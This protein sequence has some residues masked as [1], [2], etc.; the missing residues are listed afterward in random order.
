[1]PLNLIRLPADYSDVT[2]ADVLVERE[3]TLNRFKRLW[4]EIMRGELVRNSFQPWEIDILLVLEACELEPR[5]R[6]EILRQYQR[7]V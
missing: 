2:A 6:V 5:R 1:M 7:A 4:G 3:P